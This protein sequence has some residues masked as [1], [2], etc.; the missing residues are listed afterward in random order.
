[1]PSY[2]YEERRRVLAQAREQI[3]D[4]ER[5]E[6]VDDMQACKI[7]AAGY[8]AALNAIGAIDTSEVSEFDR[9]IEQ[10]EWNAVDRLEYGA[11]E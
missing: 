1:M 11:Q 6:S 10:A 9:A 4:I 5:A 2:T 7:F 3:E 8:L